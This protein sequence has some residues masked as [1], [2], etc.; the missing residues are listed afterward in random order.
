M[1][2]GCPVTKMDVYVTIIFDNEVPATSQGIDYHHRIKTVG[3][4]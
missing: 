3:K 2:I 1:V 4:L